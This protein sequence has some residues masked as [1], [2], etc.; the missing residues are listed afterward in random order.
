MYDS[1]PD[2]YKT[3]EIY[4]IVVSLYAFL[5]VYWLDKYK[6]HRICDEAVGSDEGAMIL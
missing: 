1:I 5:I 2:Q 3:Q 6:T 4:D